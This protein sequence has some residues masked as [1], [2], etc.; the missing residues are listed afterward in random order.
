MIQELIDAVTKVFPANRVGIKLGP[1]SDYGGMGS[2]DFREDFL[3][4]F[5]RLEGLGLAYVAVVNGLAFGF[6]KLG[7]PLSLDEIQKVYTGVLIANCGYDGPT[8]E[9]EVASG[10]CDMVAFG[11][12]FIPNPDLV[13]RLKEGLPLSAVDNSFKPTWYSQGEEGYIDYPAY[14]EA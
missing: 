1:H 11:R 14:V 8:A 13:T 4:Y 2:P 3:Y 10:K 7:E 6:H 5:S 12:L 9:A